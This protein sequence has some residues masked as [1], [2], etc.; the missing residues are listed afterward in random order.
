MQC[1]N[2]ADRGRGVERCYVLSPM[3]LSCEFGDGRQRDR[4]CGMRP[5]R[6]RRGRLLESVSDICGSLG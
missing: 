2:C 3:S 5:A 1:A 6:G 4:R